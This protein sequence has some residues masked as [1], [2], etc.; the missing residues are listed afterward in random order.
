MVWYFIRQFLLAGIASICFGVLRG[1]PWSA[2]VPIAF[3]GAL[4]W[5]FYV[6]IYYKLHLGL[7]VCNLLAAVG[8][9]V[10][11]FW[12]ARHYRLPMIVFN[13]PTLVALVPGGQAYKAVR[14]F[15]LGNYDLTLLYLYQVVVICGA[16]TLGFGLGDVVNRLVFYRHIKRW[17][18]R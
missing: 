5:I 7:A 11:S 10:A 17:H 8:I 9:S 18:S 12:A 2:A 6:V 4:D 15:V 13:L 3:I 14:Y 16:I 1:T